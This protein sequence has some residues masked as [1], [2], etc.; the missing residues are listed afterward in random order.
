MLTQQ[1]IKF[2]AANRKQITTGRTTPVTLM[3]LIAQGVDEWTGEPMDAEPLEVTVEA[4]VTEVASTAS[5][6][7]DVVI[8]QS[9]AEDRSDIQ[10][11]ISMDQLEGFENE[12][13]D[14]LTYRGE[15]YTIQAI[16]REGIG[17]INRLE[18]NAR[19]VVI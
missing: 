17:T 3:Y 7:P 14:R 16:D 15:L 10:V 19:K 8:I 4:V 6:S 5:G 13:P 18:L 2:I 12:R 11:S 1:D 9:I